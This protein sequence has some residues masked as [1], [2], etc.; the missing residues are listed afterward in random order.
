MFESKTIWPFCSCVTN[1]LLWNIL[2]FRSRW[3]PCFDAAVQ[4][5]VKKTHRQ[6]NSLT[7]KLIDKKTHRQEDSLTRR[8]LTRKLIDKK[9]HRQ[10]NS[11]SRRLID[12]KTLR[13][14]DSCHRQDVRAS[15]LL[16]KAQSKNHSCFPLF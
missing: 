2:I 6:E 4:L 13:Q 1:Y 7:R 11:L 9:T 15:F 16:T 3:W 10:D 12:K 8:L 5:I 14:E